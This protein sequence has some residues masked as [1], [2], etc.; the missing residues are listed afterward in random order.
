MHTPIPEAVTR[1]QIFEAAVAKCKSQGREWRSWVGRDYVY[2]II[3]ANQ[4]SLL[5]FFF[6]L[7]E[8]H[9]VLEI[10]SGTLRAAR[11]LI[12]FLDEG[13]Y[14]GVEPRENCT[15]AGLKY[16]VGSIAKARKPRFLTCSDYCFSEFGEKFD[17]VLSYSLFTH[18]PPKDIPIIFN[19]LAQV[20]KPSTIFL[21]SFNHCWKDEKIVDENNWTDRPCNAYSFKRISD[22]AA[23]AGFALMILCYIHQTWFVAYHKPNERVEMIVDLM[24][25]IPF[26]KIIETWQW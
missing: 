14:C 2:D 1:E 20:S 18:I 7:R 4:F 8:Q 9:K 19:N 25:Q 21:A 26:D 5:T 23:D 6:G 22:A 10:G 24:Q 16:E 12:P 3:G 15:R 13:N 11:F 17:A